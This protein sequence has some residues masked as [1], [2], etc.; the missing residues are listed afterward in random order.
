MRRSPSITPSNHKTQDKHH[1]S[2]RT[3]PRRHQATTAHLR[4]LTRRALSHQAHNSF[5]CC[6]SFH[7]HFPALGG[8]SVV[9]TLRLLV[10]VPPSTT[11]H[12]WPPRHQK[13]FISHA[14]LDGSRAVQTIPFAAAAASGKIQIVSIY[15]STIAKTSGRRG[16]FCLQLISDLEWASGGR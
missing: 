3:H 1:C 13:P 12:T 6:T 9:Q 15:R 16:R 10:L 4:Q 8:M 14:R 5:S 2:P 11:R 7:L